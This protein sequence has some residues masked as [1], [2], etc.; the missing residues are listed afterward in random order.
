[1]ASPEDACIHVEKDAPKMPNVIDGIADH[2]KPADAATWWS[3]QDKMLMVGNLDSEEG[4]R[5]KPGG[6]EPN[7]LI[8]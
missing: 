1:M 3:Q 2:P 8:P 6:E 5:Q 4:E 7:L